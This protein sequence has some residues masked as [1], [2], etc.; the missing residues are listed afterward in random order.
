MNNLIPENIDENLKRWTVIGSVA[1]AVIVNLAACSGFEVG[2][3]LGVYRVDTRSEVQ[4]TF[5]SN[6]P[7][8]CYL[9]ADC[10]GQAQ[11]A[12][13]AEFPRTK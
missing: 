13:E 9:W 11:A 8:K 1:G 2:G 6:L 5:R 12:D 4:Q 10:T 7:L 3:K